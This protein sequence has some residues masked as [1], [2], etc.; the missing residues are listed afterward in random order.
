[1]NS[2]KK[3]QFIQNDVDSVDV[4]IETDESYCE[5]MNGIILSKLHYSLGE[6]ME[7][8]IHR[9]DSIEKDSSGKFRFIINR[10]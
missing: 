7:I 5:E 1:M 6:D 4:Y 9:V 3:M 10:I 2:V 8:R